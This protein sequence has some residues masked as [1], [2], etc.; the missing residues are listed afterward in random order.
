MKLKD[1]IKKY[2]EENNLSYRQFAEKTKDLSHG[3]INKIEKQD[4]IEVGI[5]ALKSIAFAMNISFEELLSLIDPDFNVTINGNN[6]GMKNYFARNLKYIRKKYGLTQEAFAK[7]VGLTRSSVNNYENQISEPNLEIIKKIMDTFEI[8]DNI[9]FDDLQFK[10][11]DIEPYDLEEATV[12]IPVLGVIPAGTP[13]EAIEDILDYIEIP[14]D[15]LRGGKEFFAL[16]LKG[17]S[18]FPK[19]NDGDIVIFKKTPDCNSGDE[20]CV[21][22]NGYDA[23]FKRLLKHDSGIT[24]QPLNT[25]YDIKMYS[26]EDVKNLPI[27]VLGVAVEMRRKL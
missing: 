5:N 3:Y 18:M 22:V 7:K 8:T 27:R 20:V 23:T 15:W 16:K 17:D 10:D 19:Y 21:M 6:K 24:I 11:S 25:A 1:I 26:N 2:R 4:D 12:K 9:A 13:I 14:K